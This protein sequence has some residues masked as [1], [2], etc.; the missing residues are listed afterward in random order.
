MTAR[1]SAPVP[2]SSG[3]I[4]R[5]LKPENENALDDVLDIVGA[6]ALLHVSRDALYDEVGKNAIPHR[7]IGKLIRFSR[8]ALLRWLDAPTHKDP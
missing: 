7:R 8:T 6:A 3:A 4:D 5:D 1:N 2:A